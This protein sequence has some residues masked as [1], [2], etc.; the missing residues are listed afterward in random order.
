M[1]VFEYK[2]RNRRGEAVSGRLEGLS[3]DAVASQLFNSGI[4]PIDINAAHATAASGDVLAGLRQ[5][6]GDRKVQLVDLVLFCRQ[7]HSLLRA[8]VPILQALRNLRDSTQKS[9]TLA[10]HRQH[11]REPGRRPGFDQRRQ[12]P[13]A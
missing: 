10:Y 9:E 1:P 13:L 3:T 7:M 12:T 4:T 11:A 8:G 2:G 6:L 5:V